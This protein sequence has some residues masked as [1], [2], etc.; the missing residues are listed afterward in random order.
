MRPVR[1]A[2]MD[3]SWEQLVL[4]MS[5]GE[6]EGEVSQKGIFGQRLQDRSGC[7]GAPRRPL[8]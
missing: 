6:D 8:H 1:K 5:S 3:R 2:G 7:P 4:A